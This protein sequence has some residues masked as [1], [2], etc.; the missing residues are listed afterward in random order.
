M[1]VAAV[2][3]ALNPQSDQVSSRAVKDFS[4][5]LARPSESFFGRQICY[6]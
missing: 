5:R 4:K 6:A 3:E 2:R 1:R